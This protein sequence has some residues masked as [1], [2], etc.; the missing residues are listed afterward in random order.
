MRMTLAKEH[1][2][3]Q[4]GLLILIFYG[5]VKCLFSPRSDC[6]TTARVTQ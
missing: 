5:D 6:K 3:I 2:L 1:D 4:E